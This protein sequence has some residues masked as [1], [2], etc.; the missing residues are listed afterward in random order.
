MARQTAADRREVREV[1]H[2]AAYFAAELYSALL[3]VKFTDVAGRGVVNF[4]ANQAFELTKT[5]I[6]EAA[7]DRNLV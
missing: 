1:T 5:L 6:Y 4:N 7:K 3:A 2:D